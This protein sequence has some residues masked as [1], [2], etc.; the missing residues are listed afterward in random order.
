[1][2]FI[3]DPKTTKLYLQ[4]SHFTV[5]QK[6]VTSRPLIQVTA[7]HHYVVFTCICYRI[8]EWTKFGKLQTESL[9]CTKHDTSQLLHYYHI[10]S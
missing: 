6:V 10:T 7:Y 8:N 9:F 2:G 1:M 3:P 4:I 5:P